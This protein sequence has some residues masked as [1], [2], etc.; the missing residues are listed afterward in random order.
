MKRSSCSQVPVIEGEFVVLGA[1]SPAREPAQALRMVSTRNDLEGRPPVAVKRGG[2]LFW[3]CGALAISASFL[4]SGGA[5][6]FPPNESEPR[7]RGA[8]SLE[9]S[10]VRVEQNGAVRISAKA[11]NAGTG[12]L[13][14]PPLVL[15]VKS[16]ESSFLYP[17]PPP[18]GLV[19]AGGQMSFETRLASPAKG[20]ANAQLVL[21]N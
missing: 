17:L 19:P 2:A 11:R 6:L 16:G 18:A 21:A 7:L 4:L 9:T 14:L 10:A 20:I 8:L 12:P 3:C 13:A 5:V 15:S 1:G